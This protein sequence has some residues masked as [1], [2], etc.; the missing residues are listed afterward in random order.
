M[1][2]TTTQSG[3]YTG[4]S[5]N[6]YIQGGDGNNTINAANGNNIVLGGRWR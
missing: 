2:I 4:S 1:D 5:A 3:S 6:E